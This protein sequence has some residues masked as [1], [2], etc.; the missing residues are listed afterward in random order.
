VNCVRPVGL[1]GYYLSRE[2]G[3]RPRFLLSPGQADC[4]LPRSRQSA[5]GREAPPYNALPDRLRPT[6][7]GTGLRVRAGRSTGRD[8]RSRTACLLVPDQADYRLPRSRHRRSVHLSYPIRGRGRGLEPRI[9]WLLVLCHLSYWRVPPDQERLEL[10]TTSR[11]DGGNRT[12]CSTLAGRARYLTC[13]P[14][15]VEPA[16]FGPAASCMPCK[17]ATGLRQGPVAAAAR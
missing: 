15:E 5:P 11:G 13:H 1:A 2:P 16:G 6:V 17:R 9:S 14:L 10:S 7:T 8:P 12:R 3:C 4:R